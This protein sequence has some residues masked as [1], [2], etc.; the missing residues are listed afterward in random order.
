MSRVTKELNG[1]LNIYSSSSYFDNNS[2]L[3]IFLFWTKN[4]HAILQMANYI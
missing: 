1:C 4:M 3:M 2:L